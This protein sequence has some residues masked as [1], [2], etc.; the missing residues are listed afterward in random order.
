MVRIILVRHAQTTWNQSHRIQGGNS[1][2][3]LNDA[4]DW[5]CRCLAERLKREKVQAVYSSPL[6]RA[7]HTARAIAECHGLEVETDTALREINCGTMEGKS[8]RDI[9]ERLQKLVKGADENEILFKNCG[10]ESL[11]ELKSRAWGAVLR[12]VKEHP[13]GTVVVVS[14]YFVIAAILC[15][16]LELPVTELGRF[17]LGETSVST[18]NFDGYGPFLSLFNDRCHLM[19][20]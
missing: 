14:H 20:A 15:T 3:Q 2:T 4:G 11:Q 9:G 5:Q 17:R 13:D 7:I 16:V 6:S 10:G 8:T 12:M 1:D 18:I 19:T